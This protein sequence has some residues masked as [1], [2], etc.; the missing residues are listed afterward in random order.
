MAFYTVFINCQAAVLTVQSLSCNSLTV[1]N[2]YGNS[3]HCFLSSLLSFYFLASHP[4]CFFSLPFLLAFL[5]SLTF[6]LLHRSCLVFS[7]FLLLSAPEF[8]S[9]LVFLSSLLLSGVPSWRGYTHPD[10]DGPR[11]DLSRPVGP[12]AKGHTLK[13]WPINGPTPN[14]HAF[15]SLFV[16]LTISVCVSL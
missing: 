1:T 9:A 14:S 15:L 3:I 11:S 2:N 13:S 6:S 16:C 8:F 10:T 4:P 5:L 7:F 12:S